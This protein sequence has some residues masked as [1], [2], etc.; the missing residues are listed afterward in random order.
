MK[1]IDLSFDLNLLRVL[2]AL[3]ATRNVTQAAHAL[4]MSQSGFSTALARLRQGVDDP[5][6]IR[7]AG[8]MTPTPRAVPL[9]ATAQEVLARISNEV[10]QK[11]GFD[12]LTMQTVFRLAMADVAEIVFLPRLVRH[13]QRHAPHATVVCAT[14]DTDELKHAMANGEIDLAMGCFP[15]LNAQASFQ[16]RLYFHTYACMLRHD[17]PLTADPLS[18]RSYSEAG[19]AV[20]VSPARTTALLNSFLEKRS[21]KRRIVLQTP[22]HLSLAAI[23]ES[24]DLIAT[25]PLATGARFVPLGM[26]KL[27]PLPF[28]PPSFAIQQHWHPLFHRDPRNQWLRSQIA[29]LFT[30]ESDDWRE[31]QDALYG[32]SLRRPNMEQ[33]GQPGSRGKGRA[34]QT[35]PSVP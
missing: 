35:R 34:M 16:Q 31:L 32:P 28:T 27:L 8:S 19:H 24:T 1:T 21:I 13:L 22:H 3:A 11:P 7:T 23:V 26:V 25:V 17:H 29:Q 20:A 15:D 10:L 14:L 6:F 9:I 18:L 12:P 4:D 2:V 5:L 33:G 30:P